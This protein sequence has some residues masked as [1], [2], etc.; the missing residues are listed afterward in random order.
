MKAFR[1]VKDII[2]NEKINEI[3]PDQITNLKQIGVNGVF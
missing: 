3:Y 1:K 2:I